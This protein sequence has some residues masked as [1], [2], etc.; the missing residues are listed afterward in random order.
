MDD[1]EIHAEKRVAVLRGTFLQHEYSWSDHC[2][3]GNRLGWGIT[4]SSVPEEKSL[5]HELEKLAACAVWDRTGLFATRQLIYSPVCGYIMMEARACESGADGRANRIV[6]IASTQEKTE[7]PRIYLAPGSEWT[8][9]D[10]PLLPPLSI[11]LPDYDLRE[12]L[13]RYHL[14]DVLPDFLRAVY[15]ALT[16][17]T[18]GICFTASSWTEE[19]YDLRTREL[20]YAIHS[21]IPERLR[22][23]AGYV[24]RTTAVQ[25]SVPFFFSDRPLGSVHVNLDSPFADDGEEDGLSRGELE[26]YVFYHLGAALWQDDALAGSLLEKADA[27][28]KDNKDTSHLY[29]KLLWVF[30]EVCRT[31][32]GESLSRDYLMREVPQLAYWS[33]RQESLKG[34]ELAVRADLYEDPWTP[35]EAD[36]Y[37][38]ILQEG[39]S[40]R[41]GDTAAEETANMLAVEEDLKK[42]SLKT[43]L[44]ALWSSNRALYEGVVHSFSRRSEG[45]GPF[46]ALIDSLLDQV[47]LLSGDS[48]GDGGDISGGRGA[49]GNSG[50]SLQKQKN[51]PD[52]GRKKKQAAAVTADR[53]GGDQE[54]K[55]RIKTE[56]VRDASAERVGDGFFAF[57]LRGLTPGFITGCIIYL[58][59]YT[60]RLGHWKIAVGMLGMWI[61]LMLNYKYTALLRKEQRPTWELIG[62]C[63]VEGIIIETAAWFFKNQML[64]LYFFIVLGLIVTALLLI[65]IVRIILQRKQ[66]EEED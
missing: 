52:D 1:H 28:L 25:P 14:M 56:D 64:R 42:G 26:T 38:G 18:E 41:I 2:I 20:I 35:E 36:A 27:F 45:K 11:E 32:T 22:H 5:L 39:Y 30:Y 50:K 53:A 54:R 13:E 17:E 33:S 40:A 10:G 34:P 65:D 51:Q 23:R 16:G 37:I 49:G 12:I 7:D 44:A 24:S 48:T 63:L 6:R 8:R 19:D 47:R 4:A 60:I 9:A 46:S 58:S 21:V 66:E 61:L 31:E 59:H 29:E 3:T 62:L 55:D 57:L 43:R 15:M